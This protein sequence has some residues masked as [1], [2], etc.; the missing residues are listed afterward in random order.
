MKNV[1]ELLFKLQGLEMGPAADSPENAAE[2]LRLRGEI[3]API[4]GHYERLRARDKKG[5]AIV[6]NG[7]CC[8]CHMRMASGSHATLIRGEDIGVCGSCGR[9]LVCR[10]EAIAASPAEEPKPVKRRRKKSE[11]PSPE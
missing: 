10:E 2:I 5:V 11:V 3:P 9:Y 7:V 4:M 6:R 1:I 8:E